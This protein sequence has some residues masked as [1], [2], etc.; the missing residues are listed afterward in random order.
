MPESQFFVGLLAGGAMLAAPVLTLTVGSSLFEAPAR[1]SAW[2]NE[3]TNGRPR[4]EMATV[5]GRPVRGYVPGAAVPTQAALPLPTLQP[6]SVPKAREV[7]PE[8]APTTAPVTTNGGWSPAVVRT[9]EAGVSVRRAIGV[10]SSGDPVLPNG[11]AVQVS[12]NSSI[13]LRGQE[14]RSVRAAGGVIGWL[15][16]ELLVTAEAAASGVTGEAIAGS[17]MRVAH[18]D[19]QGVVLRNSPQ[20]DDRVPRGLLE[21]TPVQVLQRSGSEWVQVRAA[22]GLEG[23]I[24]TQY[25]TDR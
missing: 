22:N 13:R 2:I 11:A 18:T 12:S 25:V 14:W 7:P 21:G 8:L 4:M 10:E 3:S 1:T 15:P 19:G 6:A 5:N 16:A 9:T 24:P 20:P 17:S 23:W